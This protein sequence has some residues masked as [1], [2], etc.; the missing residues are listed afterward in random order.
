MPT[1]SRGADCGG[2]A[3]DS[4]QARHDSFSLR[5][6]NLHRRCREVTV[7]SGWFAG[8]QFDAVPVAV[9]L[10]K[11]GPKSSL[12]P[13]VGDHCQ[14]C[15]YPLQAGDYTTLVP[16]AA[17]EAFAEADEVHWRCAKYR[18]QRPG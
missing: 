8:M 1:H 11:Y 5:V 12:S 17:T 3:R 6:A 9:S 2:I 7:A 16:R 4:R 15:G 14:F 18:L 13:S 10:H